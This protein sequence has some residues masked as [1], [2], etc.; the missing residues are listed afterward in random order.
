M[1]STLLGWCCCRCPRTRLRVYQVGR[2]SLQRPYEKDTKLVIHEGGEEQ[3]VQCAREEDL[4]ASVATDI[5]SAHDELRGSVP[6]LGGKVLDTVLC[7]IRPIRMSVFHYLLSK[8]NRTYGKA[9]IQ[10]N[11]AIWHHQMSCL[12]RKSLRGVRTIASI[13]SR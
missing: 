13:G 1:R 5:G 4:E 12:S 2:P 3:N 6:E 9:L 10:F 7:S 11:R 8:Y